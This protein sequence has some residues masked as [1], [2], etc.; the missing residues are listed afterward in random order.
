MADQDGSDRN[1]VENTS[2]DAR[3]E[4]QDNSRGNKNESGDSNSTSEVRRKGS[5]LETKRDTGKRVASGLSARPGK[6]SSRNNRPQ[7]ARIEERDRAA[8]E[9][10]EKQED[11]D[12][13]ANG[14]SVRKSEQE[15]DEEGFVSTR[16]DVHANRHRKK[17]KFRIGDRDEERVHGSA[18]ERGISSKSVSDVE[19]RQGERALSNERPKTSPQE[20]RERRNNTRP[21]ATDGSPES[22]G[23][24]RRD[25]EQ[26]ES[27]HHDQKAL[28]NSAREQVP[29]GHSKSTRRSHKKGD[30]SQD[31][32][33]DDGWQEN[34]ISSTL[35]RE[36]KRPDSSD[37]P[38]RDVQSSQKNLDYRSHGPSASDIPSSHQAGDEDSFVDWAEKNRRHAYRRSLKPSYRER[39]SRSKDRYR[40]W[41]PPLEGR[42]HILPF[43]YF[44][45]VK[46]LYRPQNCTLYPYNGDLT[47]I[48]LCNG[49]KCLA[50]W[51]FTSEIIQDH[52]PQEH[53]LSKARLP[54]EIW[55]SSFA[56]GHQRL[57]TLLET[58]ATL[59]AKGL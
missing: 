33:T 15:Q 36:S 7:H 9:N 52:F 24:R 10:E 29:S 46:G 58:F 30:E 4:K 25:S 16:G 20:R 49:K 35:N 32:D 27:A 28:P 2:L 19:A 57:V 54:A 37:S 18:H 34:E 41:T 39:S 23:V 44:Q 47:A 31:G 50:R 40:S 5:E 45:R 59:F 14:S 51:E 42:S 38:G 1:E 22:K 56:E 53:H 21:Q 8:Y 6:M 55:G 3:Y 13:S 26:K 11:D 43:L 12:F 17:D 48:N